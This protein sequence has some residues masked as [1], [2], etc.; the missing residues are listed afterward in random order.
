M[1]GQIRT[2]NAKKE[3]LNKE[4][5]DLRK[6]KDE[7]SPDK[8][9]LI[10]D[11]KKEIEEEEVAPREDRQALSSDSASITRR[12]VETEENERATTP[13]DPLS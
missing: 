9:D 11:M 7:L 4:I 2:L 10:D 13:E 12:I 6:I 1:E 8:K 3:L 5:S